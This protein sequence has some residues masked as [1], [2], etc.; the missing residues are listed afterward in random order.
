MTGCDVCKIEVLVF[1]T[2]IPEK[3]VIC[4]EY[5]YVYPNPGYVPSE[6]V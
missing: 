1:L 4:T 6:D 2:G 3:V 5:N